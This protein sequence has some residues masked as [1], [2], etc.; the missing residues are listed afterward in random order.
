[1]VLTFLRQCQRP[2]HT[3]L[4]SPTTTSLIPARNGVG[5]QRFMA[6][7]PT[8]RESGSGRLLIKG[9][10]IGAV[11]GTG[12]ATYKAAIEPGPKTHLINEKIPPV[13]LDKH[14]RVKIA[15]RVEN[16]NDKT[17]L[18]I[19]LF[20]YQT[21]PFC[22]KVR[23]FL[24]FHGISYN[25][26]EVDGVRKKDL[27]WSASKKVPTLLVETKDHKFLQLTDSSVIVSVLASYIKKKDQDIVELATFYPSLTFY[28]DKG[29]KTSDIMNK[30]FLMSE[31]LNAKQKEAVELERK[32]RSWVDS[33]LVHMISPNV[34]R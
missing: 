8:H 16:P 23:A 30:Y 32:W 5:L 3:V 1:M 10:V 22:C 15:R 9:L 7:R 34:Y 26:V 6:T 18:N 11:L 24:D 17:G 27:K 12:Y 19:T 13:I 20:Q 29:K 2:L 33:H 21:C 14:P 25:V 31:E 4:R 28:D